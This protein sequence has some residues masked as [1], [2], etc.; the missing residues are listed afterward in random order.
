MFFIH[1]SLPQSGSIIY[2]ICNVY[3]LYM[4]YSDYMYYTVVCTYRHH[5]QYYVH[6]HQILIIPLVSIIVKLQINLPMSCIMSQKFIYII[7]N[8]QCHNVL[9]Y[10]MQHMHRQHVRTVQLKTQLLGQDCTVKQGDLHC[11]Q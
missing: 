10:I 1:P 9:L 6:M 8:T 5:L 7:L 2:N 4:W 3:R 11:G